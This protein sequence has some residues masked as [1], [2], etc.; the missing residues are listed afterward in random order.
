MKGKS[1]LELQLK[2]YKTTA[3]PTA[4]CGSETWI[5]RKNRETRIQSEEMKFLCTLTG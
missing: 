1:R 5:M 2:L 4:I 3:V